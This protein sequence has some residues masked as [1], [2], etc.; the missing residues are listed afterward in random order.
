[1]NIFESHQIEQTAFVVIF[2]QLFESHTMSLNSGKK[3]YS[4]MRIFF[5]IFYM[6]LLYDRG[7]YNIITFSVQKKEN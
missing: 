6:D 7:N 1:M 2:M 3:I 4:D 5:V